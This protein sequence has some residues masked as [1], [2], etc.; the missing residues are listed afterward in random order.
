MEMPPFIYNV[1][2]SKKREKLI[3]KRNVRVIKEFLRK[4]EEM[5]ASRENDMAHLKRLRKDKSISAST[6]RR[7][8]QVMMLT[9]EQKRIDLI[10][11]SVEKSLRISKSSV[12]D[13]SHESED[14][15]LSVSSV[16][17]N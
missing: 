4:R 12:G 2:P 10:K 8:K 13:D 16:E 5:I 3:S 6:Y 14:G 1:L 15:Q 9:H 7:L 11:T 17:N